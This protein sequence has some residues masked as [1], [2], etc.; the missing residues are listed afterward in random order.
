[1]RGDGLK[2]GGKL[3]ISILRNVLGKV[4]K[5]MWFR[6]KIREPRLIMAPLDLNLKGILKRT[7]PDNFDAR[8]SGT[9]MKEPPTGMSQLGASLVST[10][11]DDFV[12]TVAGNVNATPLSAKPRPQVRF[13]QK[14]EMN[15]EVR[16]EVQGKW[17][18]ASTT[19]KRDHNPSFYRENY[20][21]TIKLPKRSAQIARPVSVRI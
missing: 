20:S 17:V 15:K 6:S 3:M 13:A 10:G 9:F 1:M 4:V 7:L 12:K 14:V 19:F 8:K 16:K 21:T 5:S 2:W 11:P 18:V